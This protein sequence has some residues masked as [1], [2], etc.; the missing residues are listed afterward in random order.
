MKRPALLLSQ[1]RQ[2][3]ALAALLLIAL[4]IGRIVSTYHVFS[5]VYDE[6]SNFAAGIEWLNKGTYTIDAIHPPLA[7][8]AIALAPFLD[9]LRLP[10]YGYKLRV[11]NDLLHSGNRY[12]HNLALGRLGVLPFFLLA[13]GIVWVWSRS[14]FGERAALLAILL[15]TTLPPVL[16]HSS[17]ATTDMALAATLVAALFAFIR[18]LERLTYFRSFLL[19]LAVG[20]AL[21]SK[22]SALLFLPSCGLALFVWYRVAATSTAAASNADGGRKLKAIGLTVLTALTI[23]WGGYRFSLRPLTNAA[24]RPHEALDSFVKTSGTLHDSA[25]WAAE[26]IPLPALEV[27]AGINQLREKYAAGAPF[28]F[29]GKVRERGSWYFFPVALAVKTPLPFLIL[30]GVGLVILIRERRPRGD[31]RPLAPPIAAIILLLVCMPSK[32]N[33]GLRYILPV[34]PLLAIVGGLGALRLWN[35]D[36]SRFAAR[37]AVTLLLGW[38]LVSSVRSHPDY[39]AYFNEVAGRQPE[40]ILIDTDLDWGQ[41]LLR[42]VDTL[43]T[44]RIESVALD[45]FGSA[46]LTRHDLPPNRP[47]LPY[48]P[49]TGWIAISEWKLKMG[50]FDEPRDAYSWLEA[51]EPVARVGRSIRL[52]YVRGVKEGADIPRDKF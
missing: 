51:Y 47:L 26:T 48:Q 3:T 49:T 41:D 12:S 13:A 8:V 43:R 30:A 15:F 42:L 22:F 27:V 40:R 2:A 52:Y 7:R 17:F 23:I 16:A 31:W 9:G 44:R 34:Y 4:A 45:Y 11:G 21:L 37:A 38:Q 5:Q 18:S 28:Y 20:L 46:D 36:R 10:G 33:L 29:L 1:R 14:L 25:Y 39:L 32:F 35:L 6:P 50:G 19:G 24:E